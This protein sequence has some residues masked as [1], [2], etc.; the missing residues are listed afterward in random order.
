MPAIHLPRLRRQAAELADKFENPRAFTQELKGLF[1]FYG[2]RTRR[3]GQAGAPPSLIKTYKVPDPVLRRIYLEIAPL[4][5]AEPEKAFN[6][7]EMLW[8][9]PVFE[10]RFLAILLLG[11][12]PSG[13]HQRLLSLIEKWV[14]GNEEESLLESIATQGLARLREENPD[15][16]ASQIEKWL[17]SKAIKHQK[18]GLRALLA[19]LT[20]TEFENL[21]LV[22]RL[23]GMHLPTASKGLRPYLLDLLKPLARRSPLE[24]AYFLRQSLGGSDNPVIPWLVRR[25]IEFFPKDIQNSLKDALKGE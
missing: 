18:L 1:E 13:E 4:A 14:E 9:E 20:A 21:P 11:A 8:E 25:S 10:R 22:Y 12:I 24:T 16:F 3:L 17:G 6:L 2:D 7:L 23:L 5:G 19:Q 15:V